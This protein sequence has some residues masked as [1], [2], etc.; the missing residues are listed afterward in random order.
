MPYIKI[1]KFC[2]NHWSL[3]YTVNTTLLLYIKGKIA[4]FA[5]SKSKI[6]YQI[7]VDYLFIRTDHLTAALFRVLRHLRVN[8]N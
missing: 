6:P 5:A 1:T 7:E 2:Q 3:L 8:I 4:M